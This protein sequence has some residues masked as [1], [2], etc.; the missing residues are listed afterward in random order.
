MAI[1]IAKKK[2]KTYS[3]LE[4][5]NMCS[6]HRK[7]LHM[8]KMET[9]RL[10]ETMYKNTLYAY[11]ADSKTFKQEDLEAVDLQF[12]KATLSMGGKSLTIEDLASILIKHR[13]DIEEINRKTDAFIEKYGH[14]YKE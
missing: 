4:W 8:A 3:Q 1:P 5:D 9:I 7:E 10:V 6:L 13:I 14:L 11:L 2:K 12:E